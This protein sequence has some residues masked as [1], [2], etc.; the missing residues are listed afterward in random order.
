M[1]L[2]DQMLKAGLITEEQ[3]KQAAHKQRVDNKQADPKERA[4]RSQA[5]RQQAQA[6]REAERT[7]HKEQARESGQQQAAKAQV[8]QQRQRSLSALEAAYRDGAIAHWEGARRY[9]YAAEGRVEWLMV[10]EDVVRK[11]E[12]GQA[13]IVAGERNRQRH[14]PLSAGAAKRL[15]EIEP[16]RLIVL[17]ER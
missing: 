6:Q 16:A 7:R 4:Q 12:A 11:L 17:H 14:V 2:R 13:A 15:A 10:S 1:S 5:Q 8:H 9:Y 3:A